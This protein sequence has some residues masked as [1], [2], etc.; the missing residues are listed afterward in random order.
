MTDPCIPYTSYGKRRRRGGLRMICSAPVGRRTLRGLYRPLSQRCRGSLYSSWPLVPY[1][2]YKPGRRLERSCLSPDQQYTHLHKL[3]SRS[4]MGHCTPHK[5]GY[6][7]HTSLH[8][9][10]DNTQPNTYSLWA[11]C[12]PTPRT[13]DKLGICSSHSHRTSDKS[14][15]S[16]TS[17]RAR[18]VGL[19]RH[20]HHTHK[21][22]AHPQSDVRG[23]YMSY[24]HSRSDRHRSHKSHHIQS[25]CSYWRP[26]LG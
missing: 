15:L 5:T 21:S 10:L 2:S 1:T 17:Y 24:S 23:P 16:R 11:P 6:M 19:G 18:H 9:C 7:P 25:H 20:R 12:L 8:A 22:P 4:S 13:A 3:C 14:R 26:G